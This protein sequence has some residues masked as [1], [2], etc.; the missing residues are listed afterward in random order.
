[1]KR[2][3]TNDTPLF[4]NYRW[5]DPARQSKRN[6]NCSSRSHYNLVFARISLNN[7]KDTKL[8]ITN[9]KFTYSSFYLL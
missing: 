3:N 7:Q 2:E 8:T 1:M 6:A 4:P 5:N 9:S